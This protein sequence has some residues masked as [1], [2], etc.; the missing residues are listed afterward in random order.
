MHA[1]TPPGSGGGGDSGQEAAAQALRRECV[2]CGAA[3]GAGDVAG[4]M[5]RA[6]A[7]W[8]E[9]LEVGGDAKP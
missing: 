7:I 4:A 8:P 9:L 2:A 6:A 5:Q 3:A 1:D